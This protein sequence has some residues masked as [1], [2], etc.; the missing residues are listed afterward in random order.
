MRHNNLL[1]ITQNVVYTSRTEAR[2]PASQT[3]VFQNILLGDA[4]IEIKI[5]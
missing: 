3:R 5:K 2:S 1:K 4:Q